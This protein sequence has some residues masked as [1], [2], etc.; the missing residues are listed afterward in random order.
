MFAAPEYHRRLA[1]LK[2]A[3]AD[4]TGVPTR[5]PFAKVAMARRFAGP[6]T[7]VPGAVDPV[8]ASIPDARPLL[9][10]S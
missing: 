10:R 5:A 1:S 6:R 4:R 3:E 9:L 7:E 8:A 2:R